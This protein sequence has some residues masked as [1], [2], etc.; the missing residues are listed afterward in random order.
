MRAKTGATTAKLWP[1]WSLDGP[2]D[3]AHSEHLLFIDTFLRVVG[4]F[5]KI[6]LILDRHDDRFPPCMFDEEFLAEARKLNWVIDER[7]ISP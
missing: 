7:P 4:G 2:E 5:S 1:H 3:Y 6:G